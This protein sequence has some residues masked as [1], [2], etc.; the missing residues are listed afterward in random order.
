MG[1]APVQISEGPPLL[2][3]F[4]TIAEPGL[5]AWRPVTRQAIRAPPHIASL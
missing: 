1:L 5:Y 3:E 4:I 2:I